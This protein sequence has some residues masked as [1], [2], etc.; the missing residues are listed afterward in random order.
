MS[1]HPL[2]MLWRISRVLG[3]GARIP[4]V[5]VFIGLIY[6]LIYQVEKTGQVLAVEAVAVQTRS[7][8]ETLSC[9]GRLISR[10]EVPI[11]SN[12]MGRVERV[13]VKEGESVE[14]GQPLVVLDSREQKAVVDTA[15]S[16]L[17]ELQA[18]LEYARSQ[19]QRADL[20][21]Q[22]NLIPRLELLSRKRELDVAAAR[23]Q[24]QA[25][26]LESQQ[27]RLD[28]YTIYAPIR[29]VIT[30]QDIREGATAVLGSVAYPGTVLMRIANLQKI[31]VEV[32]M[33]EAD[34]G[35]VAHGQLAKI[36]VP[37][38]NNLE[39]TARIHDFNVKARTRN[40][41]QADEETFIN[42]YLKPEQAIPQLRPEMTARVKLVLAQVSHTLA[43]PVQ[44][45]VK[46]SPREES[47]PTGRSDASQAMAATTSPDRETGTLV[48]GMY[49]VA[50]GRVRFVPVRT[51]IANADLIEISSPAIHDG[52]LVVAGPFRLL[53]DLH[54]G[55]QV[56]AQ[57]T[58]VETKR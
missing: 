57:A 40:P 39:L 31:E 1:I 46:R 53:K 13:L 12:I 18:E 22:Q 54:T 32:E 10:D 26:V 4:V 55:I 52:D 15:R 50:G 33:A 48:D 27:R 2:H 38:L 43:V 34:F 23:L 7:I 11:S 5:L 28:D 14:V 29:G 44:A 42:V 9:R 35:R 21:F 6:V 51:G 36:E 56:T 16:T 24:S 8:E 58:P 49:V 37:A 45:V 25:A 17:T 47:I 41:G 3:V 19:H 20:M 30:S